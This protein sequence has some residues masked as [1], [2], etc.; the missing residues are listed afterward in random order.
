MGKI[1]KVGDLKSRYQKLFEKSHI[2]SVK[3][4]LKKFEINKVI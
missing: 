4:S 1:E 3:I 2:S